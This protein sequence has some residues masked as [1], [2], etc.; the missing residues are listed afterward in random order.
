MTYS[1]SLPCNGP[2]TY[3]EAGSYTYVFVI[4]YKLG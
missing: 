1:E 3:E 4:L 2:L